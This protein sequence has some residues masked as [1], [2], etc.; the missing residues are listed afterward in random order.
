ML[1]KKLIYG[2]LEVYGGNIIHQG[3]YLFAGYDGQFGGT[4]QGIGAGRFFS[5]LQVDGAV[6][7]NAAIDV[8]IGASTELDINDDLFRFS[9]GTNTLRVD[10]FNGI[11]LLGKTGVGA[12]AH[13]DYKFYVDEEAV[14]GKN[15]LFK[16]FFSGESVVDIDCRINYDSQLRFLYNGAVQWVI[17]ND[18]GADTFVITDVEGAFLS[19]TDRLRIADNDMYVYGKAHFN[20]YFRGRAGS[21]NIIVEPLTG[22]DASVLFRD[23]ST[24]K[25]AIGYDVGDAA[26]K[27]RAGTSISGTASILLPAAVN[28]VVM[29]S[30]SGTGSRNVVADSN[31]TL[32]IESA[33]YLDKFDSTVVSGNDNITPANPISFVFVDITAVSASEVIYDYDVDLDAIEASGQSHHVYAIIKMDASTALDCNLRVGLRDSSNVDIWTN[34]VVDADPAEE[35]EVELIWNPGQSEWI[36]YRNTQTV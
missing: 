14:N 25:F 4:F 24:T 29:P 21:A 27:I 18:G 23:G 7:I 22:N 11:Q 33:N 6:D 19:N 30:L 36:V 3:A 2:G 28:Q 17:G 8:D 35:W 10:S 26:W 16:T 20:A 9:D 15:A 12:S 13:A 5:T 34:Q 32:G 1:V 31:G